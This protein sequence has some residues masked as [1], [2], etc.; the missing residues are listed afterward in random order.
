MT[1]VLSMPG[2]VARGAPCLLTNDRLD[3]VSH[4]FESDCGPQ[5]FCG[6]VGS[7]SALGGPVSAAAAATRATSSASSSRPAPSS[8]AEADGA[9]DDGGYD[10]GA[11]DEGAADDTEMRRRDVADEGAADDAGLRRRDVATS[12]PSTVCQARRCRRE[13]YPFGFRYNETLP[14][15]CPVGRFCPDEGNACRSLLPLGG[16]CQFGRDGALRRRQRSADFLAEQCEPPAGSVAIC[17]ASVCTRADAWLGDP[18]RLENTAYTGYLEDGSVC[19][20]P[21]LADSSDRP[22]RTSS[23]GPI[24]APT[25]SI[26]PRRRCSARR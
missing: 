22:T 23:R 14:P 6:P 17:L 4:Q 21:N 25:P 12:S 24:A 13:L 2:H 8:A 19:A 26:A 1:A 3:P 16:T 18:C 9:D 20:L 7:T 5:D 15:L 11:D 10:D